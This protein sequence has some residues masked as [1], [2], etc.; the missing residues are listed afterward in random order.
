MAFQ[1]N[2][3]E[4][5]I[6]LHRLHCPLLTSSETSTMSSAI[7]QAICLG[8]LGFTQAEDRPRR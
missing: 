2:F 6:I 7:V 8:R 3:G 1:D 4:G 5:L